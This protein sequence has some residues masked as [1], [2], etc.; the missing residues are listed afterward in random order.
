MWNIRSRCRMPSI[1]KPGGGLTLTFA[2]KNED[3]R[4]RLYMQCNKILRKE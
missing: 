3:V 1:D 4:N 2:A